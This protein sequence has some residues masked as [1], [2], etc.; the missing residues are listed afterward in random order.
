MEALVPA[1]VLALLAQPGDRP[2]LLTAILAD[3]FRRPLLVA[4]AAGLAHGIGSVVAALA[5]GALTLT[6]E[7]RSLLLA[8]A[9]VAGGVTGLWRTALPSRLERWHFGPFLTPLA[10]LFVLALGEQTQFFTFALAAS[11]MP[12]FAGAGSTL[13][14]LV[15]AVAAALLGEAR[16][17]ALPLRWLRLG[18]AA[19]FL[20]AGVVIALNALDLLG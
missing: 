6:P 5:G 12:W 3:R 1:F 9:L 14:A 20:V 7:A 17:T 18:A 4:L 13:G 16:W 2:A 15:V 8:V 10:G 11:G 19:I